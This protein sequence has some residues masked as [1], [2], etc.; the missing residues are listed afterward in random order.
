MGRYR[1]FAVGLRALAVLGVATSV[2]LAESKTPTQAYLDYRAALEKAT[3]LSDVLPHLSAAYRGMLESRPKAD[4][5]EWLK[6]LKED[7]MKD[8]TITKE[9]IT[10]ETCTLLATGTSARG[11]AMKGKISLVREGGAW[12]LDEQGWST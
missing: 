7:M 4:Q 6:R 9:T 12:K 1:S 3:K 5:P 11:N 8:V 10:G 2:A